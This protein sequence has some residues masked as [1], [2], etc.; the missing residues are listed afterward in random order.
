MIAKK[1]ER[2]ANKKWF[3]T[4]ILDVKVDLV[5]SP[6]TLKW[7]EKQVDYNKQG[8]IVTPNPE[9][10]VLA[11]KDRAFK[12]VLNHASL[13]ICD[14]AGL[15]W[16]IK[17][18]DR[19]RNRFSESSLRDSDGCVANKLLGPNAN[20]SSKN[21]FTLS[22]AHRIVPN[23]KRLSGTDLML[24]LCQLAAQKHWRVF[25]LGGKEG[26]ARETAKTL[27]TKY[28]ILN[29]QYSSGSA[30]IQH[31]SVQDRDKIIKQINVFRPQLLFVAYG[32]PYQEKW[33]ANNLP[34]LKVNVAMGVGGAFDYISGKIKR[35]P[36]WLQNLGL[37]WLYRLVQ[38]PWRWRRQLSLVK[39]GWLVL[40]SFFTSST[41]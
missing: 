16:A 24:A 12:K 11:G 33:I 5:D 40:K 6:T 25:L 34:R 13:S 26:V 30:D 18:L 15:L 17:F 22:K 1:K 2:L 41:G 39:F 20:I 38:E 37:E 10:V 14:G 8:Q 35:A 29:T 9:Q 7:T 21:C 4:R 23:F 32:A 3:Q 28:Q 36:S 31:E 27:N 19:V